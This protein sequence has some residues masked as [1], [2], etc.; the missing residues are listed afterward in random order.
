M[1]VNSF[2][3]YPMAWKPVLKR[4]LQPLYISLAMQLEEDIASGKLLPG[5]KLPP[6]RELAD[7][8]DINVSTVSRAF[9]ICSRK[10]L[11]SGC[12]GSGTYVSYNISTNIFD[13]PVQ[14]EVKLI[15]LGS[16]TPETIPQEEM[17]SLL[18]KMMQEPDFDMLFQYSNSIPKWH[19]EAAA[20][21][22]YRAGCLTN[23]EQVIFASG[24]QNSIA[25][26]F[27]ALFQP[28][29]RLGVDPLVYPGIKSAARLFGIQLVAVAQKNNE[30]SEEGL[31]YAIQNEA[32]KGIYIMPEAQNPTTY[33]MSAKCRIMIARVAK[34]TGLLVIEDGI[35]N[36]LSQKSLNTVFSE[37]PENTIFTLSL[38]KTINPALRLAYMAVPKQYQ[39]ELE[40]A[41]Y[42]INLSQSAL[43]TELASRLIVSGKLDALLSRRRK[44]IALRN[45]LT[46]RILGDYE[47][48]GSEESL[49][50]WLLLPAGMTGIQFEQLALKHGVFVYGSERFAV[51]KDAPVGAVRLAV[52]APKSLEELERGLLILKDL[53]TKI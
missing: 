50:R 16:M 28:G 51:G 15:E 23:Q 48:L 13:T 1:P 38:S 20:K 22:L 4:N 12:V 6:Q 10:G 45:Q 41:L 9:K 34:E 39:S 44:G 35:N 27:V 37:A 40:D 21:L 53:L 31:R 36:L 17:V 24:G 43:L 32:I 11:L 42:N 29:D 30:M 2:D 19:K 26:V 14:N 46:D 33:T 18:Q 47:I 5:T 52:C 25:A 8:L 7:F 49:S 3:N